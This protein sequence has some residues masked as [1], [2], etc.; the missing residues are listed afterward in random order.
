M[1]DRVIALALLDR[2]R[3]QEPAGFVPSCAR[4]C[5][6]PAQ[7]DC[8]AG[9]VS[10]AA[11]LSLLTSSISSGH[12][13]PQGA[14][15]HEGQAS[16]TPPQ[17]A[18][19]RG[20]PEQDLPGHGL[21]LVH[22]SPAVALGALSAE[23]FVDFFWKVMM[24]TSGCM[25]LVCI[26]RIFQSPVLKSPKTLRKILALK[27]P[28]N[29]KGPCKTRLSVCLVGS[30]WLPRPHGLPAH[31]SPDPVACLLG[32]SGAH[33]LSVCAQQPPCAWTVCLGVSYSFLHWQNWSLPPQRT[34]ARRLLLP[35][36]RGL[37]TGSVAFGSLE[38]C[39][40][41]TVAVRSEHREDVGSTNR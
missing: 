25:W 10:H 20:W 31:G 14:L 3:R 37:C 22:S 7:Q 15:G 39:V 2:L 1:E 28:T 26:S 19:A 29:I 9:A 35:R 36:A 23:L 32:P 18:T 8:G 12:L 30:T 27:S 4:A 11:H 6:G 41:E 33:A 34:P 13:C 24:W 17:V 16:G 21:F 40:G 38:A 5:S